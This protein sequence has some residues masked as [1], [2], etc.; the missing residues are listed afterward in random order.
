MSGPMRAPPGNDGPCRRPTPTRSRSNTRSASATKRTISA[1]AGRP[2]QPA[3]A[4]FMRRRRESPP[5]RRPHHHM[6]RRKLQRWING[7]YCEGGGGAAAIVSKCP[8]Q[9]SHVAPPL[10]AVC[11]LVAAHFLE[12]GVAMT[13]DVDLSDLTVSVK[14]RYV[15]RVRF[16]V[17]LLLSLDATAMRDRPTAPTWKSCSFPRTPTCW[18]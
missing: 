6:G 1:Q 17:C 16:G 8:P 10:L 4:P 13:H 15:L 18:R 2:D 3:A 5:V 9:V 7:A 11:V 14:W 12:Q